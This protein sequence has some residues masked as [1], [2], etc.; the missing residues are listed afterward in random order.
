VRGA[1]RDDVQL[2]GGEGAVAVVQADGQR[3]GEDEEGLVGVRVAVP[4]EL[5][6]GADDALRS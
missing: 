1:L 6:L 2:A 5:A 4:G 3:A